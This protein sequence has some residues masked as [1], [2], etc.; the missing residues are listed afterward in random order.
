MVVFTKQKW[1]VIKL[2]LMLDLML[3][4][5]S[6]AAVEMVPACE[7]TDFR[8]QG[9]RACN[10]WALTSAD[11]SGLFWSAAKVWGSRPAACLTRPGL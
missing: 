8:G 3:V 6:L 7:A 11:A 2:W 5:S 4:T 9:S 1:M 10:S